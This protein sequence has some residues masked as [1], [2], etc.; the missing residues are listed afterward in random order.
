MM[1]ITM[2][3][4]KVLATL[5]MM[6]TMVQKIHMG[7]VVKSIEH[8]KNGADDTMMPT[9]NP[10]KCAVSVVVVLQSMVPMEMM[11][12]ILQMKTTPLQMKMTPLLMRSLLHVTPMRVQTMEQRIHMEMVA[13]NTRDI[14]NG[15]DNTMMPTSNPWKCAAS[16]EVVLQSMVPMEMMMIILQMK[17]IP[18]QMKMTLPLME[19]LLHV[20]P[21]RVQTMEQRI[22]MEIVVLNTRDIQNGADNTMMPT[23]TPW[24]CAASVEVV[25]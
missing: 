6:Q 15:A 21:M 13:L 14:Q 25:L 1:V 3:I 17:M 22:H 23:S 11:M 12:I 4:L 7:M 18:L 16:V 8:I 24:K 20:T 2:V 5:T 10:W 19:L 9:S